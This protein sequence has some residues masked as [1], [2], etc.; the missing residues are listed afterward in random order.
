MSRMT[1]PRLA[2]LMLVGAV[3][4]CSLPSPIPTPTP[5]P[6]PSPTSIP[7][8]PPDTGWI[9]LAPGAEQRLILTT[10]EGGVERLAL[11]RLD[12]AAFRFRVLYTPGDARRVSAWAEP[13]FFLTAN[14]GYFTPEHQAT[15][16]LVSGGE[17]Y[18]TSYGEFAGMFAVLPDGQVQ[19]RWLATQPYAPEEML[20][21]AVQSFPVLVKPGGFL[22][23]SPQADDG[24][25][26]RRTVVAQDRE[27]HILFVVAPRGYIS[28]HDMARWLVESDLGVNVAL[29]LDGGQSTGM[30]LST[31][32]P[33]LRIDS[34][35][36][37]PAVIVV[38]QR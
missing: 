29:N 18:G 23:F 34:L 25:L 35:T 16:L 8:I 6:L 10:T 38:E 24:R 7:T 28:L 36:P 33:R 14:G 13:G 22:G 19:V 9:P 26:A 12:P 4:I 3:S 27:G 21:E 37:I 11:V 17:V 30:W 15:G 32:E 5:T 31:G 2:A 1:L 20:V